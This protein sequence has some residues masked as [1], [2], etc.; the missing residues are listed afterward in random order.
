MKKIRCAE[1]C[2][3]LVVKITVL[4][5]KYILANYNRFD[6]TILYKALVTWKEKISELEKKKK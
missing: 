2:W 1:S 5:V 4:L 3:F 6:F